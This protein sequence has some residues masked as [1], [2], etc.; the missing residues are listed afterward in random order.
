MIHVLI[1]FNNIRYYLL[2][3]KV[4]KVAKVLVC[5][6][7]ITGPRSTPT[8]LCAI[9]V[10]QLSWPLWLSVCILVDLSST[11]TTTPTRPLSKPL[12]IPSQLLRPLP[13]PRPSSLSQS[14]RPA[15]LCIT[16]TSFSSL[17]TF[18]LFICRAYVYGDEGM[19]LANSHSSGLH[20]C[21]CSCL[22]HSCLSLS[23]ML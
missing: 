4:C 2:F 23:S 7:V 1:I 19:L 15:P 8:L 14:A 9:V 22:G 6:I 3:L 18:P 12:P 20:C 5:W 13:A 17:H 21:N 10:L 16:H 11:T